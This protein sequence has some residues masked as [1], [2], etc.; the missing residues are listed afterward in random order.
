MSQGLILGIAVVAGLACPAH[1]WWSHR[2]GSQ[3]ACCP[4]SRNA[5]GDSEIEALRARQQ[6]L[7]ARLGEHE[8]MVSGV[9]GSSPPQSAGK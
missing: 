6:H 1:M 2:R 5:G 3:A 8:A 9:A 7:R 4:P